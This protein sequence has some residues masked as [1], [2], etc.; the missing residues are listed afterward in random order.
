MIRD[1]SIVLLAAA[2]VSFA[3]PATAQQ[4]ID[5]SDFTNA[6]GGSEDVGRVGGESSIVARPLTDNSND[7]I[8]A[9]FFKEKARRDPFLITDRVLDQFAQSCAARS[10]TVLNQGD[11]RTAQFAERVVSHLTRPTGEKYQWHGRVAICD[12]VNGEP[13]GGLVSLVKDNS[14]V[15]RDGDAGSRLLGGLFGTSNHTSIYLFS[16]HRLLSKQDVIDAEAAKQAAVVETAAQI[17]SEREE[18]AFFHEELEVG[19]ATNCGLVIEL[20]GP[21]ANI[22]IPTNRLAPNGKSTFWTRIDDLA[23]LRRGACTYG[24]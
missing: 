23:P 13:F 15:L 22:A 14:G 20:R 3:I 8:A 4:S 12:D 24:L 9:R 7:V 1:L 21:L 11:P 19:D 5:W 18:L 16:P 10:G 2:T 6:I 17:A